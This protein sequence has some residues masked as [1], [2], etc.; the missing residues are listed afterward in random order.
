MLHLRTLYISLLI[1]QSPTP[2][3]QQ[4]CVRSAGMHLAPKK[5]AQ[6]V[7][8][9]VKIAPEMFPFNPPEG[10]FQTH[11]PIYFLVPKRGWSL[12]FTGLL[13]PQAAA[14]LVF[15]LCKAQSGGRPAGWGWQLPANLDQV[16]MKLNQANAG[17]H[18]MENH[19]RCPSPY[20]ETLDL[21][22]SG[23][24]RPMGARVSSQSH[25]LLV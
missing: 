1:R 13:G 17:Y 10:T 25:L 14:F 20:P 19:G 23:R 24:E 18:C 7:S 5:R 11:T 12:C 8:P 2:K 6:K 16:A 15:L 21:G 3:L 9:S 22:E 4:T